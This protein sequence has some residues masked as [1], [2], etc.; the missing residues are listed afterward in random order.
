MGLYTTIKVRRRRYSTRLE[1]STGYP[2]KANELILKTTIQ[3]LSLLLFVKHY[4][5]HILSSQIMHHL[6]SNDISY[7]NQFGFR[8]KHSSESQLLITI[9]DFAKALNSKKQVDIGILDFS[10]AFDKVPHARLCQKLDFYGIKGKTLSWIQTFLNNQ[11]QNV[12]CV[13]PRVQLPLEF[14]KD[15]YLVLIIYQ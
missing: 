7:T 3:C 9:D 4:R 1:V 6:E 13:L 2:R 14:R 12:V 15:Q 11:Q 5:A 8:N 10:K